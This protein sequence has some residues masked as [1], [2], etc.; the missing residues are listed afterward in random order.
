MSRDTV[1]ELGDAVALTRLQVA[2]QRALNRL[3]DDAGPIPVACGGLTGLLE[4]VFSPQPI[5]GVA[6]WS[7]HGFQLGP[8]RGTLALDSVGLAAL[9]DERRVDLLPHELRTLLLADAAQPLVE[10]LE[11]TLRLRFEWLA[12][13]DH[14]ANPRAGGFGFELRTHD[15]A[16]GL[17]GLVQLDDAAALD[18]LV[19]AFAPPRRATPASFDTLRVPLRFEIGSTPIRL[20]EVR[21]IAGGDIISVERWRAN[22][23][24]LEVSATLGGRNGVR[25]DALADGSRITLKSLG[26]PAMNRAST[27]G[28]ITT[29]EE[30]VEL[31]FDRLDAL[32]VTLRFEVGELS[33]TLG[34]L[35]KLRPGHVFDLGEP[36]NKSAVRIVAHGNLLGQGHLVAVGDRL[37][38]RVSEFAVGG[39]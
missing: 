31:P 7:L 1:T 22:G 19:P 38:I 18:A 28:P 8:H 23:Q 10:A 30:A 37:G 9:V 20:H 15:G 24:A 14:E 35:K 6:A 25:L 2:Q 13:A 27:E 36:M 16:I 39:L 12:S 33:V 5:A 29:V 17:C 11:K 26:E 34:E 32:E 4:F 21:K 3:Y